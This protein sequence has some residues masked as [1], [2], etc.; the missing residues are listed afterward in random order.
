MGK[1]L[2]TELT[3]KYGAIGKGRFL[4]YWMREAGV[5]SKSGVREVGTYRSKEEDV[6]WVFMGL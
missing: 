2:I 4:S 3:L 1:C 5:C 6:Y